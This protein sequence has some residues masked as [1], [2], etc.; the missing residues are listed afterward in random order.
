MERTS[1]LVKE[2]FR[3]NLLATLGM[4][5]SIAI[6]SIVDRI[7]VGNLLGGSAL[8]ALNLNSP[9][10]CVMNVIFDFFV[11][12]GIT[13][14]VTLKAER[15]QTGA[16]R[17]FTISIGLGT[18][19]MAI[20]ALVGFIFRSQ[21]AG[22]LCRND[23]GLLQ[24]VTDYLVPLLVLGVLII[25]ANGAC[26][27]VRTDGLGK[28]SILI[29]VVSNAVNLLC[30]YLFLGVLHWGITSAGW[31][32]NIGYAVG[33]LCLIPY[34]RSKKRSFFFSLK[35]LTDVKL[36]LETVKTGL[37]SALVDACLFIQSLTM[38]LII[39]SSFGAVG[40]EVA[41]VAVSAN[42]IA[43]ILYRGTTET[44]LPI[45]G[46]LYGEKDYTGLR[47]VMRSGFIITEVFMLAIVAILEVLA[48]PFGR[49]FG[50]SSPEATALLDVAFRLY[51]ISLPFVGAQE[52]LRVIL[53]STN[54]S[55]AASV[56]TGLSGTVCFVP[57]IWLLAA[58]APMLIWLSFTIAALLAICGCLIYLR[59]QAKKKGKTGEV[60]FP[61]A[62]EDAK[63]FEF[64]IRNTIQDA[65]KAS[66]KMI[67]LCRENGLD[68]R[69]ANYF[70]MAVEE[71]CTNI[72]KYAYK[73]HEDS[74]D[75]FFRIGREELLLRIRDNGVIF[76]PTEFVD[77]SGK[78]V[79]GLKVLKKLPLKVE[80]NRVLGFNNTIITI[81]PA[82]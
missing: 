67:S 33:M 74:V 31:A 57:V 36:I 53:Q 80:Y 55:N 37:A 49:V 34:F 44:M 52:C 20:A 43:G 42:S 51:L 76:N 59:V 21:I 56:L 40:A 16:N 32:T 7:M 70:G 69:Q 27:F 13:L 64:S 38:N 46:A 19:I 2:K 30:D 15:N 39:V 22:V 12:G 18:V 25:P 41:A 78:E 68:D 17:A 81:H 50:V 71:M 77:D 58:S 75:I 14:A 24:P 62:A 5:G 60:L 73:G 65:E 1:K 26:A 61:Q 82:S 23:A 35:G 66:E 8:A 47:A 79:T 48:R 29:P 10:I 72:A 3:G 11:F 6:A 9:V 63:T 4:V 28:L 45:G 54:R